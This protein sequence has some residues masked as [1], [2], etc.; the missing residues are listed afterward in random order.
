MKTKPNAYAKRLIQQG[1]KPATVSKLTG[2]SLEAVQKLKYT[3]P[4]EPKPVKPAP[5]KK[6]SESQEAALDTS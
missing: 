5:V 1:Y 6:Y 3:H 4:A 2:V